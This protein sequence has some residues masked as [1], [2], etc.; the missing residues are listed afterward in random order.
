[1]SLLLL[2]VVSVGARSS[3]LNAK[4][5]IL[6]SCVLCGLVNLMHVLL[7]LL[8]LG[9][10]C[11]TLQALYVDRLLVCKTFLALPTLLIAA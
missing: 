4:S 9:Q 8:L 3:P 7:P 10:D 1:M 5:F 6:V 11:S 2:I